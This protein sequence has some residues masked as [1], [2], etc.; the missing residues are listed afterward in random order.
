MQFVLITG[1]T[2]IVNKIILWVIN[3][4]IVFFQSQRM[5]K[6]A[7]VLHAEVLK[8]FILGIDSG[9]LYY[10]P[11]SEMFHFR[12]I[13]MKY[14]CMMKSAVYQSCDPQEA[15]FLFPAYS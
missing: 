11:C 7:P 6:K 8:W 4:K 15:S 14:N 10:P 12:E 13:I 3:V 5:L 2:F 9:L 1:S